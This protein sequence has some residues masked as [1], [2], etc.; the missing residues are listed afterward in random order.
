MAVL[1]KTVRTK[2][3][4]GGRHRGRGFIILGK[5]QIEG[6]CCRDPHERV[7][8]WWMGTGREKGIK[9]T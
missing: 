9:K 5:K 6:R 8:S 3:A 4:K 7:W 1:E 2:V